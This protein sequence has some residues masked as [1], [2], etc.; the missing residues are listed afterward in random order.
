MLIPN[1][2]SAVVDIAIE[3]RQHWVFSQ[4]EIAGGEG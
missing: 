2:R 3:S 1:T 4:R